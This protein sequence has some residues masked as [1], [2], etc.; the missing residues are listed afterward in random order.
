LR[1][2]IVE[3]ERDGLLLEPPGDGDV[4]GSRPFSSV[5]AVCFS[6]AAR[7]AYPASINPPVMKTR[8]ATAE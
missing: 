3:R 5:L 6:A 7:R 1:I 2:V 4:E 8:G